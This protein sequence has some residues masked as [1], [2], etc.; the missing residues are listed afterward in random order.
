MT[1]PRKVFWFIFSLYFVLALISSLVA[2]HYQNDLGFL[3]NMKG[4]I[5]LAKYFSLFGLILFG[6]SYLFMRLSLKDHKKNV[7]LLET[8]KKE[9]KAQLFDLQ[10]ECKDEK[11][12]KSSAGSDSGG[13]DSDEPKVV[14]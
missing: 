1:K 6:F 13:P 14:N 3:I 5:P 12:Q 4:Y 9:L 2:D 11:E 8:E 10:E 7:Q